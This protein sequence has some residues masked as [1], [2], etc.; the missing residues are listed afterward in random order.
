MEQ[1]PIAAGPLEATVMQQ[2]LARCQRV[3]ALAGWEIEYVDMLS[4]VL[5]RTL[6]R[7]TK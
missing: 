4:D 3:M 7:R 6:K 1:T 2:A 5:E